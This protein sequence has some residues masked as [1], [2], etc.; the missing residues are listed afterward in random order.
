MANSI[1]GKAIAG[2]LITLSGTASATTY[3]NPLG[4]F[5]FTGLGAGP[6]TI[7]PSMTGINFSPTSQNATIVATDIVLPNP[8]LAS[9]ANVAGSN[10]TLQNIIDHVVTMAELEP[11]F[12]VGGYSIEPA[13][14]I[15]TDVMAAICAVNF[16]HK[17]NQ[18][19]L[20]QFYT[21]SYQ[22]D[23]A[24]VNPDGSSVYNVEWLNNGVAF[25]INNTTIPKP[26]VE[27]ECGRSLPQRTG[28]YTNSGSQIGNPGFVIAS[29]PN[30]GLYYGTWGQPNVASSSLG[31][32]PQSGS[33]YKNPVGNYSQPF[34]PISQIQ[35]AN[36]NFLV[37]TTYGTEGTTAPLAP[38]NAP[39]GT[40]VSGSGATTVW[41]VV[42]PAGLGIRILAVPSQTGVVWQFNL[43][44]QKPP[45]KFTSLQQTL[46]P[47]PDKYTSYFRAGFVAQC[48]RY[49][50]QEK[51]RAKFEKEWEHWQRSLY[52][53]RALEDRELE[54]YS[55]IPERTVMGRGRVRNNFQGAAWPFNYPRP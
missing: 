38:V 22:Q 2:A 9:S 36:G 18:V 42:D 31:N 53:L 48:Y 6:Y 34:N 54:E 23:Y 52:E 25:D 46:A 10:T 11:I 49:S 20:P 43:L 41:T 4:Q 35:D 12:N 14:T 47:L 13:R 16:P 8:F 32:N 21:F 19:E 1:S 55:F 40:T 3:A 37:I 51:T 28:T 24:L 29:V 26:W 5:S 15:A 45:V 44:G 17:W 50:P 33:V 7:T 30:S 39:A 27:V